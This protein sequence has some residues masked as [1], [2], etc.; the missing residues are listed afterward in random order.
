[1]A[2]RVLAPLT[3]SEAFEDEKARRSVWFVDEQL[4]FWSKKFCAKDFAEIHAVVVLSKKQADL[5]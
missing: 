4:Q 2:G 1:M 3:T 5:S